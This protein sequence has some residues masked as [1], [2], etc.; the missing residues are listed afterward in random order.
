MYFTPAL[1]VSNGTL[2][3]AACIVFIIC[4]VFWLFGLRR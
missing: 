4:A 2:I 1:T 3:A